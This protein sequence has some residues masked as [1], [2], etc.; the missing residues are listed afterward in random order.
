MKTILSWSAIL[1]C[2]FA[3]CTVFVQGDEAE[4]QRRGTMIRRVDQLLAD[5]WSKAGVMPS[6]LADDAE[7]LRRAYL[8]VTGVIPRVSE[9]REFLN[10]TSDDRRERLIDRLLD[11]PAHSTHLATTWRNIMLPGGFDLEQAQAAAGMQ[12]WFREQFVRNLRYDRLVSEFLVASGRAESGPALFYTTQELQPEKLAASTAR[13]FLGIQ[14]DCAQCH[15]HPYDRWSQEEFWGYAAFF[16]RLKQSDAQPGMM[17]VSL[18]DLPQGEVML[19]DSDTVIAPKYPG[20]RPARAEDGGTRRVQLAIWMASRD[21]PYLAR[22]AVN[23]VWAH[24]FG[25]GLV[26]PVDDLG[27]QNP[28]SHPELLDELATYFVQTGFDLREMYR[29]LA[30][31][32][33]YQLS[34]QTG[35]G[36][37]PPPDLFARMAVK[38]LTPEQLYDS[39]SLALVQQPA[40]AQAT[41]LPGGLLDPRR[42]AFVAKMQTLS[43]SATEFQAGIPQALSLINGGEIGE[44]SDPDRSRLLS[45]LQAPIFND[46]Q[47]IESLF[48]A[49]LSRPPSD[50]EREHF[51]DYVSRGGAN[52]NKQK[53]LGDVL[54]ALLNS[55]EFSLNH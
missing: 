12:R 23:R 42:Q 9:V 47:R 25:R 17:Q 4:T 45:A 20:G 51:V 37:I 30:N 31:T 28:P 41:Q 44:A 21:N 19:P 50:A 24:L 36:E 32:R 22:A 43:R 29:T 54:W 55:A 14:L 34:S 2:F 26:E 16:A 11:S 46:Q 35:D 53:A 6:P 33:A 1:V 5:R 48:L 40:G 27:P 10:D 15:D 38:T 52:D 8:D 49:T 3:P 13:I 7:F 18:E 39:L